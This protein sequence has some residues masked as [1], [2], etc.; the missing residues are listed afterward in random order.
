M[1]LYPELKDLVA[2]S[3]LCHEIPFPAFCHSALVWA[4]P[5]PGQEGVMLREEAEWNGFAKVPAPTLAEVVE[6]LSNRLYAK[7]GGEE[8]YVELKLNW[9][10][11]GFFDSAGRHPGGLAYNYYGSPAKM[12]SAA[13]KIFLK[14]TEW[15]YSGGESHII[16]AEFFRK[17]SEPR[18]EEN[19]D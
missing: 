17:K 18:K 7:G 3:R 8:Q 4:T 2:Y 19:H 13:L 9:D 12:A 11:I 5:R 15:K 1:S 10:T 6:R 16:P 14:L